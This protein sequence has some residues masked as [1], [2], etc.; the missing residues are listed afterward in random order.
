[1][2]T[3]RRRRWEH[4]QPPDRDAGPLWTAAAALYGV[5]ALAA[6]AIA[7]FIVFEIGAQSDTFGRILAVAAGIFVAL[8]TIIPR[9]RPAL[10]RTDGGAVVVDETG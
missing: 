8:F 7:A 4:H 3:I 1:M 2:E 9:D 10:A 5:L 6:L